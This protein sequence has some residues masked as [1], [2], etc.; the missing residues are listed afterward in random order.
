VLSLLASWMSLLAMRVIWPTNPF[1]GG[2]FPSED[3]V[4]CKESTIEYISG[5]S[6]RNISWF[7]VYQVA[8]HSLKKEG[9][10]TLFCTLVKSKDRAEFFSASKILVTSLHSSRTCA[11]SWSCLLSKEET[12]MFSTWWCKK[13]LKGYLMMNSLSAL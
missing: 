4:R 10:E 2:V 8:R 13:L 3:R 5:K 6:S 7:S 11:I 9:G 12:M 1:L